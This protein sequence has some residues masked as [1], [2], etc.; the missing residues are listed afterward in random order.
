MRHNLERFEYNSFFQFIIWIIRLLSSQYFVVTVTAQNVLRMCVRHKHWWCELI[1]CL[2]TLMKLYTRIWWSTNNTFIL[3]V[4]FGETTT[5]KC[6]EWVTILSY[7]EKFYIW[8]NAFIFLSTGVL[9]TVANDTIRNLISL[10]IVYRLTT[11][12]QAINKQLAAY[13]IR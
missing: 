4:S 7:R 13:I 8:I 9:L 11:R 6:F 5:L 12:R 1:H 2:Q 10:T 3:I